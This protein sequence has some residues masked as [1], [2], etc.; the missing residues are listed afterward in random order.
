MREIGLQLILRR[1]LGAHWE[2]RR[3]VA[4]DALVFP[5][6]TGRQRDKDN[7]RGRIL[8]PAIARANELLETRG[9][10]PLPEGLS[11][12]KL[13][14]TFASVL[15]ACG[16]DP[17]SVMYQLGHTDPAFTLRVYAHVMRRSETERKRLLALVR[18]DPCLL[19][20]NTVASLSRSCEGQE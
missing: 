16:E 1:L 8:A 11:P 13:R 4:P 3:A 17:A 9:S 19:R 6:R 12:H 2:R 5:T 15:V 14:H 7:I 20:R 18:E 10:V